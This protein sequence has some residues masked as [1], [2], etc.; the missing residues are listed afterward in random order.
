MYLNQAPFQGE[1]EYREKMIS[2]ADLDIAYQEE[3]DKQGVKVSTWSLLYL[4]I[5]VFVTSIACVVS[6]INGLCEGHCTE[7]VCCP[8]GWLTII[9]SVIGIT[10]PLLV[11]V[12][13]QYK[14]V[15]ACMALFSTALNI[16]AWFSLR[17][18]L[19]YLSQV[20]DAIDALQDPQYMSALV[21]AYCITLSVSVVALW[22]S[23]LGMR[24]LSS[25]LDDCSPH[26]PRAGCEASAKTLVILVISIMFFTSGIALPISSFY[27]SQYGFQSPSYWRGIHA[28]TGAD[29]TDEAYVM[30]YNISNPLTAKTNSHPNSDLDK[31]VSEADAIELYMRNSWD[32]KRWPTVRPVIYEIYRVENNRLWQKYAWTRHEVK[33]ERDL[34]NERYLFHGTDMVS[35]GKIVEGGFDFRMSRPGMFGI[36][37][38]FARNSSKSYYYTEQ[39]ASPRNIIILS[40]V[41]LG[42][43]YNSLKALPNLVKPEAGYDSVMGESVEFNAKAA[44]QYREWI[45]YDRFLA[46][47]EYIV[48][49]AAP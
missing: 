16:G 28:T 27:M 24:A 46:Y 20:R 31:V 33:M 40:R 44:L 14:F 38:Y 5:A 9:A 22:L 41:T 29:D 4:E 12:T 43:S 7:S 3:G 11:R 15:F 21:C 37:T 8:S 32:P 23:A 25:K 1:E 17:M 36:G 34:T 19:A 45:I 6:A 10:C 13:P 35:M 18:D 47:P 30:I 42:L 26:T 48:V 39:S 2:A 49:F